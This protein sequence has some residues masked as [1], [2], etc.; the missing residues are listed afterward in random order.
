MMPHVKGLPLTTE[1]RVAM[2]VMERDDLQVGGS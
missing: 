2:L 1:W